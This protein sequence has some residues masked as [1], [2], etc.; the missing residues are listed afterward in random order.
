[1][2]PMA[3]LSLQ[4]E[5]TEHLIRVVSRYEKLAFLDFFFY[6]FK[7]SKLRLALCLDLSRIGTCIKFFYFKYPQQVVL[8]TTLFFFY[9]FFS[10]NFKNVQIT[11]HKQKI[12]KKLKNIQQDSAPYFYVKISKSRGDHT[13]IKKKELIT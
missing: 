7:Q 3:R 13:H 2:L 8:F 4:L 1:M 9:F 12:Y 11:G 5:L 10:I 6:K